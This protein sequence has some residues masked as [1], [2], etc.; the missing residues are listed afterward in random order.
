L[1]YV[2]YYYYILL[3]RVDAGR[4]GGTKERSMAFTRDQIWAAADDLD[5]AGH[6]PTLA[7]VRKLVGGG[8]FTTISEA[9]TEWK[10]RRA[11]KQAPMREPAPTNLL[12]QLAQF[13]TDVWGAALEH[14]NG[15]LASERAALDAARIQLEAE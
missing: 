8:S 7:A 9:M 12:E 14:A 4:A 6:S 3:L 2:V 15:R 5:A 1:L 13:G 10:A 11:E